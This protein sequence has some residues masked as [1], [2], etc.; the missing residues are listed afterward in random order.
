MLQIC[1]AFTSQVLKQQF[2]DSFDFQIIIHLLVA[3]TPLEEEEERAIVDLSLL[4]NLVIYCPMKIS[5]LDP[6]QLLLT[7]AAWQTSAPT[8][9]PCQPPNETM[10]CW[11]SHNKNYYS[12][13]YLHFVHIIDTYY[14]YYYH[15][16]YI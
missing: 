1:S 11:P 10:L 6:D 12:D 16:P 5:I 15:N 9:D 8:S 2:F 4:M 13:Y 14:N 7:F 3:E